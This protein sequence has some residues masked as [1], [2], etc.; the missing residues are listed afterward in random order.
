MGKHHLTFFSR[1]D[2]FDH[3]PNEDGLGG[4][5]QSNPADHLFVGGDHSDLEGDS[6]TKSDRDLN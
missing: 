4:S 5:L 3:G 2:V 6:R 1:H